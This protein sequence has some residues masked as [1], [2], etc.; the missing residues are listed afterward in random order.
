MHP[1]EHWATV[2]I[3]ASELDPGQIYTLDWVVTN[4]SS[5]TGT[6]MTEGERTWVS[7]NSGAMIHTLR[8]N[9]LADTSNACISIALL[10]GVTELQSVSNICWPSASTADGDGDGVYDKVDLCP[11]TPPGVTTQPDGCLDSDGD[12]FDT[13]LELSCGSDP[14]LATSIPADLDSDQICDALDPD[15][16][17]DGFLDLDEVAR[18]PIPWIVRPSQ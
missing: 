3:T 1:T 15:V 16:D 7:G 6:I 9:D 11:G 2:T 12:G 10:A 8:F 13:I 5:A 17:G 18:E 14:F 4:Q